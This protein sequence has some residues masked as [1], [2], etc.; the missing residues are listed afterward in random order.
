[1]PHALL[2]LALVA[3]ALL[4]SVSTAQALVTLTGGQRLTAVDGAQPRQDRITFR[5]AKDPALLSLQSPLC[6]AQTEVR[7]VTNGRV[8]A[9]QILD[10]TKWKASGPGFRYV[11]NPVKPG[12]VRRIHYRPGTLAV[13]LQGV[14]YAN[15]PL[16][17]PVEFLETHVTI[18]S[19]EYCGRWVE[20]PGRYVK[21]TTNR[22]VIRGPTTACQASG[23]DGP[24]DVCDG[25]SGSSLDLATFAAP[26]PYPVGERTLVLVDASRSTAPNGSYPGSPERRLPTRVWYPAQTAS[27]NA[28]PRTSDGPFPIVGWAHGFTSG[29]GEAMPIGR[30]LASHGYVVVAPTFPLSSGGAPGGPTVGDMASQPA[31]VDFVMDQLGAGAAGQDLAAVIDAERRGMGGLS[32]GGGTVLIAAYHPHWRIADLDAAVALA[33]ASCFFGP[34]FYSGSVPM[35]IVAGDADMLVPLA[36]PHR[37]F[38]RAAPPVTMVTLHGANHIGFIGID[39][40]GVINSDLAIACPAVGAAGSVMDPG[41]IARLA[42][43]LAVGAGPGA[44]DILACGAVCETE[45]PQTMSGERQVELTRAAVLAHLEAELRGRREARCWLAEGLPASDAAMTFETR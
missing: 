21:N 1:M 35:L 31:D 7:F 45:L 2:R 39:V 32:L 29:N 26:G 28:P 41:G 6:P 40:P 33:P 18:G 37:A 42:A 14:P 27:T 24:G 9:E 30:H 13:T 5:F 43:E 11:D 44:V 25:S 19:A 15:D 36:D 23:G 34:D 20:R 4:A 12:S 22:I 10:C 3:S 8:T 17:G 16:T 38:E